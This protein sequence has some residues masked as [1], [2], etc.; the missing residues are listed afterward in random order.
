MHF[1][2][3]KNFI[4]KILFQ[5]FQNNGSRKF[6]ELKDVKNISIYR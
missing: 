5:N 3:S 6:I 2:H 1:M 4:S